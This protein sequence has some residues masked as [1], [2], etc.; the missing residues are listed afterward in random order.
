MELLT[1]RAVLKNCLNLIPSIEHLFEEI[2]QPAPRKGWNVVQND[3]DNGN[4]T[5]INHGY[6]DELLPPHTSEAHI[7]IDR[8]DKRRKAALT[9]TPSTYPQLIPN[10]LPRKRFQK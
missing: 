6:I 2:S 1:T 8:Q 9:V 7:K 10:S 5:S 4:R 3:T